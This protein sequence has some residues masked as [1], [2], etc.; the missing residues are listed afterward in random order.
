MSSISSVMLHFSARWATGS[1]PSTSITNM[2]SVA[3]IISALRRKPSWSL[4]QVT[5]FVNAPA[6]PYPSRSSGLSSTSPI[7]SSIRV[8]LSMK[9][10][11]EAVRLWEALVL[12]GKA[13]LGYTPS[14]GDMPKS[15]NTVKLK[16]KPI[17]GGGRG[18][19][20]DGS[21]HGRSFRD[22]HSEKLTDPESV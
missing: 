9:C 22:P 8:V 4:A 7:H 21:V 6:A 17:S 15:E 1:A 16:W 11:I 20:Q 14:D 13:D 19:F 5:M 12:F 2:S 18:R 10:S 3:A